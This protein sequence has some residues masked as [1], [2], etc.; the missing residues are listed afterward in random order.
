MPNTGRQRYIV[1]ATWGAATTEPESYTKRRLSTEGYAIDPQTAAVLD[2]SDAAMLRVKFPAALDAS[3]LTLKFK[4]AGASN[5][6][7]D[8]NVLDYGFAEDDQGSDLAVTGVQDKLGKSASVNPEIAT[9]FYV[10]PVFVDVNGDPVAPGAV[11]V[12]FHIK[13]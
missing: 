7:S 3:A 11:S 6:D 9:A 5:A 2:L 13:E 8:A 10:I 12:E 1:T 4:D